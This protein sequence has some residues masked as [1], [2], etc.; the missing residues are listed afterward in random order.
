MWVHFWKQM[1]FW[2]QLGVEMNTINAKLYSQSFQILKISVCTLYWP[3]DCVT[4]AVCLQCA[5]PA[6]SRPPEMNLGRSLFLS[7]LQKRWVLRGLIK[8]AKLLNMTKL[9]YSIWEEHTC[10]RKWLDSGETQRC[11]LTRQCCILCSSMIC[12]DKLTCA[13]FAK[14]KLWNTFLGF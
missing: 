1:K 3:N 14:Q 12:L 13:E 7:K 8:Y 4:Q 2:C 5:L 6:R 11:D 9:N 10:F